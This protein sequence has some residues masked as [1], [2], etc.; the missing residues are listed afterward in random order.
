MKL[1]VG[2]H[3]CD[4]YWA[5]DWLFASL[6]LIGLGNSS[7]HYRMDDRWQ[8]IIEIHQIFFWTYYFL[9]PVCKYEIYVRSFLWFCNIQNV[10]RLLS[11][12]ECHLRLRVRGDLQVPTSLMK[13]FFIPFHLISSTAVSGS[14]Y[15]NRGIGWAFVLLAILLLT[16]VTLFQL[17]HKTCNTVQE[18]LRIKNT[19]VSLRPC[20]L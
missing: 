20:V 10:R 2:V 15:C 16:L 18:N 5:A 4:D 6:H 7:S 17:Q 13:T 12:N 14:V 8:T 19:L 3:W 11:I 1:I 9:I